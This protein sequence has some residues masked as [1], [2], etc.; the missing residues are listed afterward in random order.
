MGEVNAGVLNRIFGL[1]SPAWFG[2]ML[3]VTVLA[4][5]T[6]KRALRWLAVVLI[7]ITV[8]H[9]EMLLATFPRSL[10]D[11]R[12]AHGGASADFRDGV[13]VMDDYVDATQL[14]SIGSAVLL[15]V[16]VTFGLPLT[17]RRRTRKDD[18][19]EG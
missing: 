9:R 8:A 15:G 2:V 3:V 18:E 1:T 5:W 7:C 19:G 13:L 17:E 12:D 10:F 11:D 6:R 16:L 14:Y 4:L